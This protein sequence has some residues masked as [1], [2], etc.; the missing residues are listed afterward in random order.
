MRPPKIADA[1]R[2]CENA[3]ARGAIVIVFGAE[4]AWMPEVPPGP[5]CKH[6]A[7][8]CRRCGRRAGRDVARVTWG[9]VGE[10]RRKR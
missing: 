7:E 1:R 2:V 8:A 3:G 6:G 5:R 9:G 10:A 4:Q